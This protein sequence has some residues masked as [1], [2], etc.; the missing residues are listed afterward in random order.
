MDYIVRII[1]SVLFALRAAA[2][3][4]NVLSARV[5]KSFPCEKSCLSNSFLFLLKNFI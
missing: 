4:K 3:E 2:R 5:M 1:L